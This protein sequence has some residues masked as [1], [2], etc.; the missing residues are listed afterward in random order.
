VTQPNRPPEN[1]E[2]FNH[3]D[4]DAIAKALVRLARRLEA[5]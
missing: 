3:L 5:S 2:R 4:K 1:S